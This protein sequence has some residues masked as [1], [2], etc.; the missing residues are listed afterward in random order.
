[1]IA[2][3]LVALIIIGVAILASRTSISIIVR[4]DPD[5]ATIK[6]RLATIETQMT[7]LVDAAAL[8]GRVDAATE[9]VS[10][11]EGE[12]GTDPAP[13]APAEAEE[14]ALDPVTGLPVAPA[15]S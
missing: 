3:A 9:R 6:E 14:V 4:K 15:I 1:M 10:A 2:L 5:M 7:N 8:A 12:I 13:A 11:I